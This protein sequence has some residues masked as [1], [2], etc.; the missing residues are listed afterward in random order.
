M[1]APTSLSALTCRVLL[2]PEE[3]GCLLGTR[4]L[5]DPLKLAFVLI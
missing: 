3:E 1:H 2:Q 4:H 5:P